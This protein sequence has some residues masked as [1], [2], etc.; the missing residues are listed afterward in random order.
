M[1]TYEYEA[2]KTKKNV[3]SCTQKNKYGKI[4]EKKKYTYKKITK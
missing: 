1:Y 2:D 4:V 3:A